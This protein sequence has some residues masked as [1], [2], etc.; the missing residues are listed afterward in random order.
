[1][2]SYVLIS[3]A[4]VV[5][6]LGLA[7][8]N[9]DKPVANPYL[10]D[11]ITTSLGSTV[12]YNKLCQSEGVKAPAGCRRTEHPPMGAERA[13]AAVTKLNTVEGAAK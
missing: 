3:A 9:T 11:A 4:A 6:S 2:R 10:P 1:M 7:G 13:A 8:C 12:E 5:L